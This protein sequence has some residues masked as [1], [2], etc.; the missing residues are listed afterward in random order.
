MDDLIVGLGLVLVLEGVAY[1]AAPEGM[2]RLMAAGQALP[3]M[4]LRRGGLA[5]AVF[6]LFVVWLA[7][8]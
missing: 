2:K 3:A 7:R 8:S 4:A 6:G 5:A 1:A